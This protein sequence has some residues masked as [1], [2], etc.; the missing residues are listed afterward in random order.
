M[1][2]IKTSNS[3]K[4]I[5]FPISLADIHILEEINREQKNKILFRV[6]VLH[7]DLI[8][9]QLQLIRKST[10]SDGKVINVLLVEYQYQNQDFYHYILIYRNTF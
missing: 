3:S 9:K 7:D 1:E 4:T 5:K 8:S 10:F 6:N 2:L